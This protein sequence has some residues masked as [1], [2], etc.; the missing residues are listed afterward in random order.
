MQVVMRDGELIAIEEMRAREGYPPSWLYRFLDR[1]SGEMVQ[2]IGAPGAYALQYRG[3]V[4]LI[5]RPRR[6]NQPGYSVTL[7]SRNGTPAGKGA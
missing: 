1:T 7:P 3:E 5:V 2:V 4:E 6:N